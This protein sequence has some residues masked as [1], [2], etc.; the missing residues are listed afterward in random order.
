MEP[1]IIAGIHSNPHLAQNIDI[2][3]CSSTL[4]NL[5]RFVRKQPKS[6]RIIVEFIDNTLFLIRRENLP[7]ELIQGV[8]GYGHT[9]P[10]AYTTWDPSIKKST[11]HQRLLRYSFGGL[12]LLVRFEADGYL[13]TPDDEAT[14]SSRVSS[15]TNPQL[16][17]E[18]L[19]HSFEA[20][21]VY[22][23]DNTETPTSS[24]DGLDIQFAGKPVSQNRIFDLKT[25][26]FWKKNQDLL[27]EEV[28]R[29][30]IAQ[31]DHFITAYHEK[32]KFSPENIVVQN[33]KDDVANWEKDQNDV[34]AQLVD[35]LHV[36]ISKGQEDQRFEI[37]RSEE[38]DLEVRKLLADAGET[39]SSGVRNDWIRSSELALGGE[40]KDV[41][42]VSAKDILVWDDEQTDYTACSDECH[43]CG[44]CT[45]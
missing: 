41:K 35:L 42:N 1:T 10:Q 4:G 8:R 6:F 14:E 12:Q 15:D 18:S 29:L 21:Q 31:I 37:S 22:G 40:K 20:A 17:V 36:L 30:W 33:V 19:A 3:A 23:E 45:Y 39:L 7:M 28:P 32:G 38:G 13:P 43:Y 16:G 25:R 27:S 26:S 34:L 44:T 24:K 11:S 2:V 9:F 5:L